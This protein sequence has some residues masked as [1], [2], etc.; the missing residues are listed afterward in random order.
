MITNITCHL[1]L[2]LFKSGHTLSTV[3][4]WTIMVHLKVFWAYFHK[5]IMPMLV[6]IALIL[7]QFVQQ[8]DAKKVHPSFNIN[9]IL[10]QEKYHTFFYGAQSAFCQWH[11]PLFCIDGVPY[12]S[13]KQGM[14]SNKVYG[15]RR[16]NFLRGYQ[17]VS[18]PLMLLR[19]DFY[20]KRL[21]H[22]NKGRATCGTIKKTTSVW[23]S[24]W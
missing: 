17:K 15:W 19:V 3:H 16:L 8:H 4:F 11:P 14:M 10:R 5:T 22:I 9:V 18:Y 20:I 6:N 2:P 21:S 1:P 13:P 7:L 23:W 12:T 24:V